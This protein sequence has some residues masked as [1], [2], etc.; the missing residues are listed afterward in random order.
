MPFLWPFYR[1]H[2][3]TLFTLFDHLQ[4]SSTSQDRAVEEALGFVLAHRASKA[5]WLP[6]PESLDLSWVSDKWWKPVTGLG[7]RKT[8][9]Q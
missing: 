7:N 8:P 1:S 4:I 9:P 3:K 2:R 6:L 5:A